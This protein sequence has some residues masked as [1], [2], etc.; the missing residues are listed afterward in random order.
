M[1]IEAAALTYGA[2]RCAA[3]PIATGTEC[4]PHLNDPI[5]GV[6]A[7]AGMLAVAGQWRAHTGQ[8]ISVHAGA[9]ATR[10]RI[11][12]TQGASITIESGNITFECPGTITY[13]AALRNLSGPTSKQ[14]KLPIMPSTVCVECLARRA[15]TRGAFVSKGAGA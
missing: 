8:A 1:E 6:A 9:A 5:I 12:T 11:A 15:A 10:V 4:I 3:R 13:H 2:G 7:R 14:Y